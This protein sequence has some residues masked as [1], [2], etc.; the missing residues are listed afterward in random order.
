MLV[1]EISLTPQTVDRFISRF[2]EE[3]I[4][5]LHSKLSLGER[6]DQWNKIK[7]GEAKIIIG[8]R[9][10]IFAP[11]SDLGM[12][13]IDEE[14]DASY[15]SETTPRYHTKEIARYLAKQNNIPLLL[16]SAT[17]DLGS[18]YQ[19]QIGQSTLLT[20]TKRANQASL[21]TVEIVD[22]RHELEQGNKSMIS[23]KLH[24]AI[25]ENLEKHKQTI[26]FLN[27][28]GFSTFVMCRDCGHTIKCKNCD[29]TLTYHATNQKLKCHYC[30][31]EQNMVKECPECHG[32]NIRYFGAG[33]QK[34]EEQVHMLFPEA[35]TIRMDVDT[36][37]KKNSHEEILNQFKNNHIDI[38]IGTQMV[39]K[40]HHFPDVTLV[41]VIAADSSLNIDDFKAGER[42]FQLLT[43]V[44]GR[45][46]R[47]G[48]QGNVIIQTYQPDHFSIE[49][50]KKQDYLLFYQ[51]EIIMR[52]QLKYPPFC[53][54]IV[55]GITSKNQKQAFFMTNQIHSY[56][57]KRVLEENLGMIL[58]KGMPAPIDKIKSRYR[59]RIIIKC[60]YDDK[61]IEVMEHM[62]QQYQPL[63]KN[64][65]PRITIDLNP[66]NWV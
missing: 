10:A 14:H 20:L 56:F 29:I 31:Y 34:L 23:G 57:K 40:G 19:T 2:G 45:A 5:V 24:Q 30:G 26:L 36:V 32:H 7:K 61:M 28:R 44:A 22:L 50:A 52:K 11:V 41:G 54:I 15:K 55:I 66:N 58:Y 18:Y 1:P 62:L 6:F 33:T 42:T 37:S 46:G 9:S 51:T 21:P 12:I 17:P 25:K 35:S 47:E 39:V 65:N 53:D 60:K 3:Q 63:C 64:G 16:G 13:I 27:R 38:L 8:A 59:F 49:C 48:T 4:A 43:Q